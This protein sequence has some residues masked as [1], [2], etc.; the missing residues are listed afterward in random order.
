MPPPSG[1]GIQHY[2]YAHIVWSC[3]RARARTWT[4]VC[5]MYGS[6]RR[7]PI[8]AVRTDSARAAVAHLALRTM[9]RSESAACALL[10]CAC[11]RRAQV[12]RRVVFDTK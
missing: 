5:H 12:Y 3:T 7:G 4:P 2:F 1:N 8:V 11:V 10:G 6:T 9:L